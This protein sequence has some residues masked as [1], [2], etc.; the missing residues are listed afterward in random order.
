ME[1]KPCH[2]PRTVSAC[3]LGTLGQSE[4]GPERVFVHVRQ[5]PGHVTG[6]LA[7]PV[8]DRVVAEGVGLAET[9]RLAPDCALGDERQIPRRVG[10]IRLRRRLQMADREFRQTH[11]TYPSEQ[12]TASVG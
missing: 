3:P 1:G 2:T 12:N 6:R 8:V 4:F 10:G 5:F 7:I 9:S 11:A